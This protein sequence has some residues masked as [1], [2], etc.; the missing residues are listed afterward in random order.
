[1]KA[2]VLKN[3]MDLELCDIPVP[4]PG[5]N[6]A[7]IRVIRAGVCGSDIVVY[8]GKHMT[9]T[10]PTVLS[11]EILGRIETLPEGYF[12]PFHVGQRVL[13]NP[14][15]SCGHCAA[16]RRG[17]TWV[18]EN[19]KLLGIHVD[20]GFAE[21]TKVATDKA[22]LIAPESYNIEGSITMAEAVKYPFIWRETGSATRKAFESAA[23]SLNGK[24]PYVF[25]TS[26]VGLPVESKNEG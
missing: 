14:I 18:C 26:L 19:L 6:E 20:G 11:H 25:E 17:M 24:N 9:A 13:M 12:G 5:E 16:C 23:V 3:W 21:Y 7:L 10:V 1:M 8:K 22:V 4:V 15:I 2:A